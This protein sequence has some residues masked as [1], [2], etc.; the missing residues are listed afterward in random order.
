MTVNIISKNFTR[1][2]AEKDAW[3]AAS[4]VRGSRLTTAIARLTLQ[5]VSFVLAINSKPF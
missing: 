5:K 4:F 3:R 1:T 2:L